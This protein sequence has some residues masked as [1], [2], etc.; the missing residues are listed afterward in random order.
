MKYVI[1]TEFDSFGGELISLALIREDREC[2]YLIYP[3]KAKNLWVREN[4]VPV[5]WRVPSPMPGGMPVE[6]SSFAEGARRIKQ[7]LDQDKDVPHIIADWPEDIANFCKA[8]MVD[9][10]QMVNIPHFTTEC[11]RG[12]DVWPNMYPGAVQH[13]AWWDATMFLLKLRELGAA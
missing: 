1:D 7:F 3:T 8:L 5:L 12:I 11:I 6:V 13:N 9:R 4:V 10:G 2:I